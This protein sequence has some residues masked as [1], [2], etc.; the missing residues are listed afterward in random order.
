[1]VVGFGTAGR[2][3]QTAIQHARRD[4]MKVGLLRPIT[5]W[6]FPE[7]RLSALADHVD[8]LLVV[9]MNAGQMLDDVRLAAGGQVPVEFYGRTGGMV[10]VPEEIYDAITA[11]YSRLTASVHG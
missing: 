2:I 7:K 8:A 5:L 11:S 4:G 10:P 1:M 9:E 3:A 6:P